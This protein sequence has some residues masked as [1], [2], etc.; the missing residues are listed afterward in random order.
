MSS[1][2]SNQFNSQSLLISLDNSAAERREIFSRGLKA[3]THLVV[4]PIRKEHEYEHYKKTIRMLF[5][6]VVFIAKVILFLK[7]KRIIPI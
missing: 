6:I 5:P 7:A 1:N 3:Q 4:Y 2:P